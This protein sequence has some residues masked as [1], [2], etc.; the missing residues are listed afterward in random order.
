MSL[1]FKSPF[2]YKK[3]ASKRRS[4]LISAL[5][6]KNLSS[7]SNCLLAGRAGPD[8]SEQSRDDGAPRS[9]EVADLLQQATT[10]RTATT[11]RHRATA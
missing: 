6:Y 1:S 4:H 5:H 11:A 9:Q 2:G 3:C 8:S 7:I 10:T